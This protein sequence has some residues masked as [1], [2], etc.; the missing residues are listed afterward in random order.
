MSSA[1]VSGRAIKDGKL[2]EMILNVNGS[3]VMRNSGLMG[4][5]MS[6]RCIKE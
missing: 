6:I 4:K 5:G 1:H 2:Q 3:M